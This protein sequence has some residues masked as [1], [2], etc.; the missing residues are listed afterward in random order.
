MILEELVTISRINRVY[1][2]ILTNHKLKVDIDDVNKHPMHW[3][4]FQNGF[5][6]ART[7]E[8]IEH[9]PKYLSINQIPHKFDMQKQVPNDSVVLEFLKK[10]S[11]IIINFRLELSI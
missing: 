2:L 11:P 9:S 3:I 5:L 8:I 10:D 6:D 7:M 1:Q 4:N